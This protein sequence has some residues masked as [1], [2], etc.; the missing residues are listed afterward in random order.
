MPNTNEKNPTTIGHYHLTALSEISAFFLTCLVIDIFFL[1][2]TRGFNHIS[3]HPYWIP[4]IFVAAHYGLRE[5]GI[6]ALIAAIFY[7]YYPQKL[8][9]EDNTFLLTYYFLLH[10][11][12]FIL[13]GLFL[14]NIQDSLRKRTRQMQEEILQLKKDFDLLSTNYQLLKESK[15]QIERRIVGQEATVSTM[16]EGIKRLK[17][18]KESEIYPAILDLMQEFLQV[19]QGS[20]YMLEDKKL[21]LKAERDWPSDN[22]YHQYYTRNDPLFSEVVLKQ[23][24]LSVNR[25]EDY[26]KMAGDRV[27]AVIPII[28]DL[29]TQTIGVLKI[30]DIDFVNLNASTIKFL[31]VL[32]DWSAAAIFAAKEKG[33]KLEHS[34]IDKLS[35]VYCYE[36]FQIV[37]RREFRISRRYKLPLSIISLAIHHFAD[38]EKNIQTSLMRTISTVLKNKF[39][40]ADIISRGPDEGSFLILLP[41]TNETGTQRC[42]DQ[43][44]YDITQMGLK[45]FT[46]AHPINVDVKYYSTENGTLTEETAVRLLV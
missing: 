2:E 8:P 7:V 6:A 4:I 46:P 39:R 11:I 38:M 24:S 9:A 34:L 30:E 19:K 28:D 23:K 29:T 45:P 3:P 33:A 31:Q 21:I 17:N 22:A 25:M 40:N 14:G 36:Y 10:P 37:F 1:P 43:I 15:E 27:L 26:K 20:I 41:M 12:S 18:L 32:A 13:I 42:I 35:E 16:Y 44:K 5:G